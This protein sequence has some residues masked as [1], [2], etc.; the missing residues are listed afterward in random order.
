MEND[1][2]STLQGIVLKKLMLMALDTVRIRFTSL[3][4]GSH[5]LDSI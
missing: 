5:L 1:F 3:S 2:L 4:H